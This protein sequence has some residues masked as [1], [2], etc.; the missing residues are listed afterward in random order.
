MI[1]VHVNMLMTFP[2]G[3]PAELAALNELRTRPAGK[4]SVK[5]ARRLDVR[6]IYWGPREDRRWPG[7][8]HPWE[9][10]RAPLASGN[11]GRVYDLGITPGR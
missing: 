5:A 9:R 3:D 7:S 4:L 10:M 11:W 6:Y 2:S 1:G 8:T